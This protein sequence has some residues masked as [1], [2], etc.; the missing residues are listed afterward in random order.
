M[1]QD[2]RTSVAWGIGLRLILLVLVFVLGIFSE[3]P[4]TT[5]L[6]QTLQYHEPV[7]FFDSLNGLE[8]GFLSVFLSWIFW[9]GI[10]FGGIGKKGDYIFIGISVILLALLFSQEAGSTP[11]M[12]LGLIGVAVLGNALG[13]CLKVGRQNWFGK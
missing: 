9:M 3:I 10:L 4:V 2:S 11:Q 8:T 7:G 6:T 1:V 13:Y 12:Y 5:F